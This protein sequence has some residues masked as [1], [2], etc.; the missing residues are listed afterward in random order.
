[1]LRDRQWLD[2]C[3][4]PRHQQLEALVFAAADLDDR[5]RRARGSQCDEGERL[6]RCDFLRE[7]GARD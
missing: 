6:E 3:R 1:V 2:R 4:A 5:E 7:I